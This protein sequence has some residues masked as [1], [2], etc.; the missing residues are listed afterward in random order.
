MRSRERGYIR[1]TERQEL[2][3]QRLQH[4]TRLPA[5]LRMLL[6]VCMFLTLHPVKGF[7]PRLGE[8]RWSGGRSGGFCSFEAVTL[9]MLR[10]CFV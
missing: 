2:S 10:F 9:F 4:Q 7:R 3:K 5:P 1:G 8:S 6:L